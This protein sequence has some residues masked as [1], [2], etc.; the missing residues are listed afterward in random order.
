MA[1][2]TINIDGQSYKS[3]DFDDKNIKK[4]SEEIY[5]ILQNRI[6]RYQMELFDGK[7]VI[8]PEETIQKAV[9]IIG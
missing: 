3:K 8:L 5:D 1:N 2:I 4:M 9:F 6:K 7:I